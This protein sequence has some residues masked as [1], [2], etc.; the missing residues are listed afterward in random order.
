M[1][2]HWAR[3]QCLQP[4]QIADNHLLMF[5]GTSSQFDHQNGAFEAMRGLTL[6]HPG[7]FRQRVSM[8]LLMFCRYRG[9]MTHTSTLLSLSLLFSRLLLID[10]G[11]SA[12]VHDRVSTRFYPLLRI[13]A[14]QSQEDLQRSIS[15][16]RISSKFLI[17]FALC[18]LSYTRQKVLSGVRI[19]TCWE[20]HNKDCDDAISR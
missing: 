1:D 7:C 11:D 2:Q 8:F 18:K 5:E 17:V 4:D 14:K 6:F 3:A 20:E 9:S 10:S 16:L 13:Y 15:Y 12:F 19:Q